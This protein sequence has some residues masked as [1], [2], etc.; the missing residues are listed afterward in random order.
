MLSACG[1]SSTPS[2]SASAAGPDASS[3]SIASPTPGA[4]EG[5]T[6][7]PTDAPS[8][9]AEPTQ[10]P[11]D[12][13]SDEPSTEPSTEPSPSGAGA[14]DACTGTPENQDFYA[15]VAAAV[16][17]S[18]YCPALP[19]GWFV[20]TGRYGLAGGA[21]LEISYR[22][23]GGAEIDLKEG[24]FCAS[25]DGCVPA[26]SDAGTAAFGDRTGALVSVG[27]GSWA[28]S[29]DAGANPSWLLTGTGLAEEAF[30]TIAADLVIVGS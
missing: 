9:S 26:G 22:G 29:V 27:D 11:T 25:S 21:R 20:R 19:R 23:P 24:A 16:D 4:S 18:V 3:G 12:E 10:T 30:R 8:D 1:G 14:A 5:A 17:W 2:T 28:L 15:H 13:P 6:E 7:V